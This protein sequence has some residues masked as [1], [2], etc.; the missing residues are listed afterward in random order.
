MISNCLDLISKDL[1]R[2]HL[3][4]IDYHTSHNKKKI[5]VHFIRRLKMGD[6]FIT[7]EFTDF[8]RI[9][10]VLHEES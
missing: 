8:R 2:F 7:G 6:S 9:D 3:S 1:S 4:S 10:F 5:M